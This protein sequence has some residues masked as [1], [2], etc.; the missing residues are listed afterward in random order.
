MKW[1]YLLYSETE[2]TFSFACYVLEKL[3]SYKNYCTLKYVLENLMVNGK[4]YTLNYSGLLPDTEYV[5]EVKTQVADVPNNSTKYG[6]IASLNSSTDEA[7]KCCTTQC[8]IF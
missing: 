7:C 3:A 5:F 8:T 4:N 6:L 1:N 2:F